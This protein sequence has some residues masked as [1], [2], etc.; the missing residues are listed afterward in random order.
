MEN[1][2]S[3]IVNACHRHPARVAAVR[4]HDGDKC[5]ECYLGRERFLLRFKPDFYP[6]FDPAE[7]TAPA[8]GKSPLNIHLPEKT[9][10]LLDKEHKS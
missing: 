2:Q 5:W 9:L 3:K 4:C 10:A 8:P 6:D 7:Q 1:R